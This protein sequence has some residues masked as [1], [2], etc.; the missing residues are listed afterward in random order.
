MYVR[1]TGHLI[2]G[3]ATISLPKHFTTLALLDG[4]TVQ[5][6][7]LSAQSEG[8]CVTRKGLDNGIDVTEL[9]SGT[10]S[11]E[12][13]WEVKAVRSR[14]KNYKVIQPSMRMLKGGGFGT[15]IPESAA[16]QLDTAPVNPP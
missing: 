3:R 7:P 1:G 16:Q 2:N 13:D 4:M 9:H 10:G 6:T 15:V 5:L 8:L 14:Y 12:F 11:Y